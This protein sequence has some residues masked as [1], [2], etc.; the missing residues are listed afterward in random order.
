MNHALSLLSICSALWL[1][2]AGLLA[3]EAQWIGPP[4]AGNL[5]FPHPQPLWIWLP[6]SDDG[7]D[8]D[9][10]IGPAYFSRVF[11]IDDV[12][13][14]PARLCFAADNQAE[15]FLNGQSI[16]RTTG[17][18]AP[19]QVSAL[20]RGGRNI[21]TAR[22][23][24]AP[25]T[26]HNPAGLIG[27]ISWTDSHRKSHHLIT[28]D[29]WNVSR[30]AWPGFPEQELQPA[31]PFAMI[32]GQVDA[33]PWSLRISAFTEPVHP[34]IFRRTFT[35]DALPRSGRM[36]ITGLG[37]FALYVNGSPV[38][39][40]RVN[41][42]WSQ[43]DRRIFRHSFDLTPHLAV[44]ENVLAVILGDSFWRVGPVNDDGRFSKTDAMPDFSQG[45]PYLLWAD[46]EFDYDGA[47]TAMKLVTDESWRCTDGPLTFSHIYAGEDFDARLEPD[48][49]KSPGFDDSSWD[50]VRVAPPPEAEHS[51]AV[52]PPMRAFEVFDPI[53]VRRSAPDVFVYIFPQNCSANLRYT[54]RGTA[55]ATVRFLPCE[56]LDED[57]NR[58]RFTYTWGTGKAIW[59]DYTLRGAPAAES[60][61][62]LLCYVGCRYVEV[63][64]AV[65]AGQ[66]NPLNRPVLERLQLVHVRTD[67]AVAGHFDCSSPM[68]NAAHRL[69]DWSIRSNMAHVATDCPHREK[70][71]WQE[72]NWHMARAMS[73]RFDLHDFQRKIAQD[74]R[75]TQLPDGHIPTNCPNYL[76][77]IGPHGFW[78]EAPEWGVAGVLLPWHL[79]EWYG[80][81]KALEDA[82]P[83]MMRYVDYLTSISTER[84]ITS[85]L[86]DWYDYG[87]GKGDG[88]SQWTPAEVS[89]TGIYALAARTVAN[90]ALTLGRTAD[91]ARY[92]TLA[93]EVRT[94]F[95]E[96]FWDDDRGEVRNNGS[97]QAANALAW[98]ADL[99]PEG[100]R[101]RAVSSMV[102]DLQARGW[103]QT[104][105]EVLQVFL[106]R[107]LAE[108]GRG[109]V[110]HRIF[111]RTERGSYGY[112][113]ERGL[114]T[115]PESWDARPGTGNSMNHFMLGHLIEWHFAYVA[116]I[117]QQPGSAGWRHLRIE[118]QP[119][120][121]DSASAA[122]D[123]PTGLVCCEWQRT[124]S[125]FS[126]T[127]TVPSVSS[128]MAVLPDGSRHVLKP[129]SVAKLQCTLP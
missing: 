23:E 64:G 84:V 81:R 20:L 62:T 50:S 29:S 43:Y 107:A 60:H 66:E 118:P 21:I 17:W 82:L 96:R 105:G 91:A 80:D 56:F 121:L 38:D 5:D 123:G 3:Q 114:T 111:S 53:E 10:P 89:A 59:Q 40:T 77:G 92:D 86:G 44:G 30:E 128:A 28:D 125:D 13:S 115:L 18:S 72:Q 97:C 69:I 95:I 124:G 16:L 31:A 51:P 57:T 4:S 68:Q 88:A 112:M 126:C 87:H 122:F 99:L 47:R 37:H 61:E 2:V 26:G 19:A 113:V 42:A 74:I 1:P 93:E 41:Q 14:K 7:P 6:S 11:E 127:V 8:Q 36:E 83:S 79:Y 78:N 117:R 94:A 109:D 39:D 25:G 9:A 104:A 32:V 71:G 76:V 103:Q 49:W 106:I 52:A 119:G 100:G 45:E 101:D 75:D 85:N 35:L 54:L 65:P 108:S 27:A 24:N 70:N 55:G 90:A 33:P 34:P 67:N 48:G 129:N 22:A 110:L 12:G 73:Y 116:G 15:L 102:A 58:V 46:A 120:T 98:C 63:R